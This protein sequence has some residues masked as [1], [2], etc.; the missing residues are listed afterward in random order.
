MLSNQNEI[1]SLFFN[2]E[3]SFIQFYGRIHYIQTDSYHP[4]ETLYQ[5]WKML[6]KK[7]KRIK[8]DYL[9]RSPR[10][11]W[12]FI[13][14]I[15]VFVLKLTGTHVLDPKWQPTFYSYLPLIVNTQF[16]ASAIYTF[17]Y[18]SDTTPIRGL[19]YA[20]AYAVG[21]PVNCSFI[22]S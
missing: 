21:L 9:K 5:F 4:R 16:T 20:P 6:L 8:K 1:F 10:G 18:Y 7:Y 11:K 22:K 19:L 14:A 12:E 17:W 2:L 13:R 15:G 3:K